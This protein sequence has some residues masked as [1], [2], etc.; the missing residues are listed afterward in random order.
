MPT[1]LSIVLCFIGIGKLSRFEKSRVFR[2]G[3]YDYSRVCVHIFDT[4][5]DHLASTSL[6]HILAP[7]PLFRR[8]HLQFMLLFQHIAWFGVQIKAA[9]LSWIR[10]VKGFERGL[11]GAPDW[12][13]VRSR[14]GFGL[15][16]N[17]LEWI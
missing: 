11:F 1:K 17:G 12:I 4:E 5:G 2:R 3:G 15:L 10:S 6:Y 7:L 14:S 16:I 9:N 13:Q 8:I